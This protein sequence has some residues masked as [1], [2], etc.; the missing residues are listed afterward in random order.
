MTLHDLFG[1]A[2]QVGMGDYFE[3]KSGKGVAKLG[4]LFDARTG[5][6]AKEKLDGMGIRYEDGPILCCRLYKGSLETK[7]HRHIPF[8]IAY[9][10]GATVALAV[11]AFRSELEAPSAG[12]YWVET[13]VV[14][15]A[16]Q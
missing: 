7:G 10:P 8:A 11:R 13:P 15:E 6:F 9:F 12:V 1:E 2:I 16:R 14:A 3:V 4:V 5:R